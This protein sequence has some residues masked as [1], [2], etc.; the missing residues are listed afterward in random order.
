[1]GQQETACPET[2]RNALASVNLSI[3]EHRHAYAAFLV[4]AQQYDWARAEELRAV[5]LAWVEAAHDA[6]LRA[7]RAQQEMERAAPRGG[8]ADA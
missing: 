8:Q 6:F 5:S 4:S 1:M 3:C 2:V 7:C